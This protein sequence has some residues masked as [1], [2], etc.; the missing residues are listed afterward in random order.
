MAQKA[1]TRFD[2]LADKGDAGAQFNLALLY[3]DGRDRP[4]DY[5]K[6]RYW[7]GKAARQGHPAAQ[8]GLALMHHRG[9]GV[10]R[11]LKESARW[12][13]MAAKQGHQAAQFNLAALYEKG[14]GVS[15]DRVM[16]FVWFFLAGAQSRNKPMVCRSSKDG[17]ATRL[18][19]PVAK[20][21]L[22][23]HGN[24]QRIAL[25][26]TPSERNRAERLANEY[27]ARYVMPFR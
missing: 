17:I 24:C 23:A 14:L 3:A 20:G 26:L 1:T 4:R 22:T 10:P 16:A 8:Y 25:T 13:R 2:S 19:P 21:S 7:Y 9:L 12:Y 18:A 6:A 27:C 5:D 15:H 11:N